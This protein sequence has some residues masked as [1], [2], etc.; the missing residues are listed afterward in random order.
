MAIY[1]RNL[2]YWCVKQD[3]IFKNLLEFVWVRLRLSEII[4]NHSNPMGWSN[5]FTSS[6]GYIES[7][8][9]YA[10]IPIGRAKPSYRRYRPYLDSHRDLIQKWVLACAFFCELWWQLQYIR[11]YGLVVGW[12]D[13]FQGLSIYVFNDRN[14]Y[15]GKGY[16]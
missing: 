10:A 16:K 6:T 12:G 1:R 8:I 15:G 14:G 9:G 4:W 5:A 7:P 2:P 3:E 11:Q 13:G